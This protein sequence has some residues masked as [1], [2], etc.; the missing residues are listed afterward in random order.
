M[1]HEVLEKRAIQPKLKV[2]YDSLVDAVSGE[3][4]TLQ[5]IGNQFGVTRERIRQ[6][7]EQFGLQDSP[8]RQRPN[9]DRRQVCPV[10]NIRVELTPRS[11]APKYHRDCYEKKVWTSATCTTCDNSF[12]IRTKELELRKQRRQSEWTKDV[13]FCSRECWGMHLASHWGVNGK[14]RNSKTL[15]K[16][17]R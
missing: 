6:L 13:L 16:P 2:S 8:G 17:M 7:I 11:V 5:D 3:Y 15:N 4:R 10:C 12:R 9:I 14:L 1:V